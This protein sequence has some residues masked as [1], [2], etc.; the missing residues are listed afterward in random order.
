MADLRALVEGLGFT[1]VRTLLNSGNVVFTARRPAQVDIAV[2]IERAIAAQLGV[3]SG[4]TVLSAA[5][6]AAVVRANPLL[7]LAD[8]HSRLHVAFLKE[9]SA[10]RRLAGLAQQDW[11]PDA[12]AIGARAAYLW[13]PRGI[14]ASALAERVNRVLGDA[15]TLRNWATVTKVHALLAARAD[16]GEADGG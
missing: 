13:C 7:A 4:V 1:D 16:V 14:L 15:V 2:R 9:P 5:E 6:L 3:T 12:L 11:A 10:R 8:D